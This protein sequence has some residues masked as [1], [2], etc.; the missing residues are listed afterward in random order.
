MKIIEA[1]NLSK[2]YQIESEKEPY[3]T[4]RDEMANLAKKPLQ[5]LKGEREKKQDFW[6]LKNVS[7]SVEKGEKVGLIGRNGAGKSTLLKILSRVTPLTQGEAVIRGRVNSI[8]EVGIGFHI[9]LTGR[10]NIYLN[11]AIL[12]M[13]K[14]EIDS[15]FDRIV[16]F[17]EFEKFLDTPV[18]KCSS[19]M[20]V[21]LAFAVAAHLEPD[22]LL[23]D[24]VLAVGDFE[25]RKKCLKK[26]DQASKEGRTVVF[27]SHDMDSVAFLCNRTI[28]LDAGRIVMDGP[29]ADVISH[30]L[31]SG[32]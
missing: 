6:A 28:L 15:K 16:Q 25:F 10:D 17:A 26:M 24:E 11:G 29:T 19:G 2:C 18:K 22:V 3:Y 1:H 21:R 31:A 7:F 12:G 4:L 20:H 13:T 30:Y 23:I 27:V 32:K 5:W 9:E 14:K 8:L